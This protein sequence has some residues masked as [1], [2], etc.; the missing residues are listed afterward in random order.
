LGICITIFRLLADAVD[1]L[2]EEEL[3]QIVSVLSSHTNHKEKMSGIARLRKLPWKEL[4]FQLKSDVDVKDLCEK[5]FKKIRKV[6]NFSE[7]LADF[8][9]AYKKLNMPKKPKTAY[10]LFSM[11]CQQAMKGGS[12]ADRMKTIAEMY[13][14]LGEKEKNE[15]A[16][17]ANV[18]REKYKAENQKFM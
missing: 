4:D 18:E 15:L 7:M 9:M 17:E 2:T 13:R 1:G 11:K 3:Q 12:A 6:R 8:E 10:M 5:V 16:E 14:N